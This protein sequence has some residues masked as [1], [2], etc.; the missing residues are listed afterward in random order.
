MQR[1]SV[2]TARQ[3]IA[4]I[5]NDGRHQMNAGRAAIVVHSFAWVERQARAEGATPA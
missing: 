2:E 4:C 5:A 1:Y 3:L